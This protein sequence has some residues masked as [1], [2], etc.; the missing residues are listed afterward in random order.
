MVKFVV[1]EN[2]SFAVVKVLREKDYEVFSVAERDLTGADDRSVF[3]LAVK[4]GGVIITRDY[5]FKNPIKFPPDRTNGI[6]Y[7]RHGNLK[8]SQEVDIVLRFC[9]LNIFDKILG[10]LVIL[11]KV[12]ASLHAHQAGVL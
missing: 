10:K 3:N 12:I 7:I 9:R 5:H 11:F 8:S 6:I 4:E 1:D 2:V